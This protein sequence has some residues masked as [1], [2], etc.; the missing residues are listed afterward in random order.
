MREVV[1]LIAGRASSGRDVFEEVPVERLDDGSCRVLQSP[2]LAQ[3][4]AAG[5]IIDVR[6]DGTF[7]T[8]HRG[9]NVVVQVYAPRDVLGALHEVLEPHIAELGGWLDGRGAKQTTGSLVYTIPITAGFDAI[10][11]VMRR[12]EG[13]AGVDWLYGNVYADDG[14]PLDWWRAQ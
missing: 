11:A 9:G 5:D 3:G 10:D 2:G 12:I 13:N 7:R 8:I 14:T 4:I 1:N 6:P